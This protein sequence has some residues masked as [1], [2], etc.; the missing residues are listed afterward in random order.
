MK[1]PRLTAA[2][3]EKWRARAYATMLC[4]VLWLAADAYERGD[5]AEGRNIEGAVQALVDVLGRPDGLP[6]FPAAFAAVKAEILREEAGQDALGDS[7][8]SARR[9]H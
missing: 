9:L 7:Q 2:Q 6:G 8:A 5:E 3:L 4:D 1:K